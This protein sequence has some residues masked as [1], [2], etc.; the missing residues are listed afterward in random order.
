MFICSRRII[1]AFLS[2]VMIVACATICSAASSFSDINGTEY[3]AE[4]AESLSAQG[5]L[6]GYNDGS[7]GPEK[8]ITRAEMAAVICR[9]IGKESEAKKSVGRTAYTDVEQ[10]HWASGYINVASKNDIINGDSGMFRPADNVKFEE[11]I[12]M[13]VCAAGLGDNI[14][15]DKSDWS[16]GYIAKA[17]SNGITKNLNG[18]KG[19]YSTRGDIAVMV[20]N[21]MEIGKTETTPKRTVTPSSEESMGV[22]YSEAFE[23]VN[24]Y[25]KNMLGNESNDITIKSDKKKVEYESELAYKFECYSKSLQSDGNDGLMSTIYVFSDG[26]MCEQ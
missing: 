24:N 14:V 10:N 21:A 7:F 22:S 12:K 8:S 11:A 19:T 3:Y 25:I 26:S 5:I 16:A 15:I 9:M 2:C 17:K 20:S 6:Q 1:T 23:N 4:A 13:V 18:S